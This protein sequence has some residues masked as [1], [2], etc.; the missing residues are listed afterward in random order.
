MRHQLTARP[1]VARASR[2][3]GRT[4]SVEAL[5]LELASTATSPTR[6]V[7]ALIHIPHDVSKEIPLSIEEEDKPSDAHDDYREDYSRGMDST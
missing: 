2:D 5:Q 4:V 3:L 7:H 6:V 1:A